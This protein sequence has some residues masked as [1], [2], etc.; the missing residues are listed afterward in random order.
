ML[1]AL[2]VAAGPAGSCPSVEARHRFRA[3]DVASAFEHES[4][5]AA[6]AIVVI[7]PL[8]SPGEAVVF[9]GASV[10]GRDTA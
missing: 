6:E 9:Q 4:S 5:L 1:V 8:D 3:D 7:A 10:P 2:K